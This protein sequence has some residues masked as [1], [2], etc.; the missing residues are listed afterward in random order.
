MEVLGGLE[1]E[2]RGGFAAVAH[3]L[4]LWPLALETLVWVVG[5]EVEGID[6][7]SFAAEEGLHLVVDE[8]EGLPSGFTSGDDRLVGDHDGYVAALV[9]QLDRLGC[10]FEEFELGR[11]AEE[12]HILV[13]GAIAI[14]E[15]GPL[16]LGEV[17][18]MHQACLKVALHFM[19][20]VG[21]THVLDVLGGVVGEDL[22]AGD[23]GLQHIAIEIHFKIREKR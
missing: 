23:G 7:G 18:R 11:V 3:A 9:D 13:E 21:R 10:A 22:A 6:E 5:A 20:A 17:A 16:R 12:A 8:A 2:A 15:D 4:V 19:V 1:Q 14:E